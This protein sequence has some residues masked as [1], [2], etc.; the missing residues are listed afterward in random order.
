MILEVALFEVDPDRDSEFQRA[1]QVASPIIARARGYLGHSMHH[2]QETP[3]R[4]LLLVQWQTLTDHLEGFRDSDDF[5]RWREILGPF[6]LSPPVV[7]HY[8][9]IY[10]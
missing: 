3:R 2:C 4:Y 9:T 1:V 6:F 5:H 10:P 8:D 7:E